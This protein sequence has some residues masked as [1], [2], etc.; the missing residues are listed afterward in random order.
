MKLLHVDSSILGNQSVSR[1]LSAEVVAKL[2]ASAPGL[3]VTYRDLAAE[4]VPHL[5]GHTLPAAAAAPGERSA[6][7]QQDIALGNQVLEEFLAA[8]IVVIGAPMYN[9]GISSQLKSWIDRLA[10]ANKTFRYT[11][12]GPEGLAGA[13]RVI[14]VS[15]RGGFYGA[16]TPMA[17]LDLQEPYLRAIFGFFGIKSIEYVR[18]E[19]IA[20]GAEQRQRAIEAAKRE[21]ETLKAA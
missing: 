2:L 19:G 8:D 12:K 4:H 18:A 9:F 3:E 14:I 10:I 5:S 15:S 20:T 16:D 1:Q 6:A 13:K 11:E 7:L 17:P 21:I